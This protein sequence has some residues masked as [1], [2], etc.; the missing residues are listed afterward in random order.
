MRDT[1]VLVSAKVADLI[2][3]TP[4][5]K[6]TKIRACM[7]NKND[8]DI[9]KGRLLYTTMGSFGEVHVHPPKL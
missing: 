3:V 7:T 2:E 9:Y 5:E 8:M 4:H 6:L 1:P